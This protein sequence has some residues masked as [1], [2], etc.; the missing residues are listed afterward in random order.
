MP[1]DTIFDV[2]VVGG[3]ILGVGLARELLEADDSLGLVVLE[4]ESEIAQH[5]TGHNSG[6]IHSGIYYAP[7]SLKAQ[8]CKRG[9][10]LLV[11]YCERRGI[12]YERCG[13]IIVATDR[14]DTARL[15]ALHQRGLQNGIPGLERLGPDEL[16]SYAPNVSGIAGLHIPSAGIVDYRA[17]AKS[18]A[19]DVIN[20]GGSIRTS[21]AVR[22]IDIND[23]VARLET[24]S[25][26]V[27]ARF[28]VTCGGLYS[29]RL[30]TMTGA[31]R[32]PKIV[33]FRGSYYV[34]GG[35]AENVVGGLVYPVP[36]PAFPFL[37]VHFTQQLS[38][39][40]WAGPNAVVALAREAYA[41]RD[42]RLRELG[43]T[44]AYRGFLSLA[45]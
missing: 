28:V 19:Q 37:G 36:D 3:G 15:E 6:V 10:E 14:T 33:P 35:G 26:S 27:R 22:G 11:E 41:K 32:S 31:P 25:G 9:N 17:V 40:V 30:A 1:D 8:L 18:F 42:F 24:S 20:Y 34:L 43:E 45:V 2:V 7:G 4:K 44:L 13:K 5:Q 23:G 29:D 39:Q 38:G 21:S 12:R 16:R